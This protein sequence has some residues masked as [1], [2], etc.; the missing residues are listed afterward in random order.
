[1]SLHLQLY[2]FWFKNIL[3]WL[4]NIKIHFFTP[5]F[6]REIVSHTPI[7]FPE[8]I[9]YKLRFNEQIKQHKL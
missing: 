7:L 1:M 6:D 4:D 3:P 8:I 2:I 5:S 9:K